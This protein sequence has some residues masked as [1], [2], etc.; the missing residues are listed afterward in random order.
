M[1]RGVVARDMRRA[2]NPDG[3]RGDVILLQTRQRSVAR[4]AS[5]D[6]TEGIVKRRTL[7]ELENLFLEL[8]QLVHP[9][10]CEQCDVCAIVLFF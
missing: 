8:L 2:R 10:T 7:L 1:D 4:G 9:I 3:A 6:V 5:I